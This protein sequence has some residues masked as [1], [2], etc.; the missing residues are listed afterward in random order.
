MVNSFV[1]TINWHSF[2][3]YKDA[4]VSNGFTVFLIRELVI[5]IIILVK[6]LIFS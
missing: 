2:K 5:D 4:E 6:A 1:I 3:A